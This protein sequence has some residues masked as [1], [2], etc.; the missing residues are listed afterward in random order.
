LKNLFIRR[1]HV[2]SDSF[3]AGA[4]QSKRV[5]TGQGEA[6]FERHQS[7]L[8]RAVAAAADRGYWSPFA[9][10]PSPRNYGESAGQEGLAAFEALR[11]KP[12]ALALDGAEGTV[13]GEQSPYGFAL[14]I[15][16]P[17]VPPAVLLQSAA[18]AL[19]SWRRAGPRVW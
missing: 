9:E 10:S 5:P 6:F 1:M 14:D 17:R 16:Y 18:Q 11:G 15:T 3:V 7:V 8:E 19:E 12:F 13:G 2:S 4:A